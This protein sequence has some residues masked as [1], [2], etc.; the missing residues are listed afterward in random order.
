MPA[1]SGM[2]H[3]NAGN[4]PGVMHKCRQSSGVNPILGA[5]WSATGEK[6]VVIIKVNGALSIAMAAVFIAMGRK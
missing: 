6:R 4:L 1:I 2:Q 3:K 5:K